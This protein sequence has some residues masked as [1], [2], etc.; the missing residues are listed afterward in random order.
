MLTYT[1]GRNL[2]GKMTR[3]SSSANLTTGDSL[4]NEAIR[5]VITAKP[6]GFRQKTKTK[7]TVASQQFYNNPADCGRIV[8]VTV[9]VGNTTY[10]PKRIKSREDWD[11][12]NQSSA[13]SNTPEYYFPFGKTV[14]FYPTPS[15]ATTDAITFV[16]EKE[17]KDLSIADYTTGTITTTSGVT[18]TGS[19]TSWT[20]QMA[21]RF[22]R[23]T[24]SDTANTGDGVWYEIS[25][26]T[27][28]TVLVLTAPYAGTAIAAGSAAY[29]I[30]QVSMIPENFQ[31]VPIHRAVE[32]H[33]TY[34][35][36]DAERA[37]DAKVNY[38]EGMKRMQIELGSMSI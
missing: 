25:S 37:K 24:N 19:G 22:I 10:T 12:I 30:G 35:Q 7:D 5:E 3:D 33:F 21:G 26:V 16:Y 18:I 13:T 23:I 34:I 1:G 9:T 27:S 32:Q 15:S 36:P 20:S 14:G 29:T 38:L 2:F 28:A 17:Q 31:I 8:N 6:W 4:I 11:R